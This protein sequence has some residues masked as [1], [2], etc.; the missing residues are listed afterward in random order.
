LKDL[1]EKPDQ[2]EVEQYLEYRE[3]SPKIIKK[4]S[5]VDEDSM[6]DKL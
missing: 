5:S 3:E 1:D 6:A 4:V 2:G